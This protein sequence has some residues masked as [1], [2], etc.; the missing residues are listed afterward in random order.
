M[1]KAGG[2]AAVYVA[3]SRVGF[4]VALTGGGTPP[5]WHPAGFAVAA[6][7]LCGVTLWPGVLVGAVIASLITGAPPLA[8]AFAGAGATLEALVAT[9]LLRRMGFRPQLERL[10]DV[11]L[12]V[13]ATAIAAV[14]AASLGVAGLALGGDVGTRG[15]LFAWATWAAGDAVSILLVGGLLLTWS[16]NPAI[17]WLARRPRE[18]LVALGCVAVASVVLFFDIFGLRAQGES[19]AFPIIPLVV[20]V[21]FRVGPRGTTLAS[22]LFSVIALVATNRGLGPFVGTTREDSLL[23]LVIFIALTAVS[24][25]AV[26][27]VVAE[28]E[29]SASALGSAVDALAQ[30]REALA[31]RAATYGRLLDYSERI[32]GLLAE[33]ELYRVCVEALDAVVPADL[34]GLTVLE[35]SSGEYVVR[36]EQGSSG[37]VGGVIGPGEGPAGCA[38]RDRHVVRMAPYPRESFPVALRERNAADE[39]AVA[40]GIPLLRDDVAIGSLT[41]A[42]VDP[43]APFTDLEMEALTLLSHEV[44]LAVANAL[45]HT[46]VADRAI[47]D[48]LT[49]LHNRRYFDAAMLHLMAM[50]ARVPAEQRGPLSVILFDLD[51]FGDLNLHHGHQ[52]GDEVL[53]AFGSILHGRLR[54]ADLV[55]RYGG[56]EFI[57]VLSGAD[58]EDALRIA[59]EIRQA[60]A[61]A[62]IQGIDGNPLS[63]TVSAG[64]TAVSHDG[65]GTGESLIR[66]ADVGLIMAKRSGR[67]RVVAA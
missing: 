66:A 21:A 61:A 64:C 7:F 60:L 46:E 45:L 31:T 34:V 18:T 11:P 26:A 63:V 16:A 53:R 52:V 30:E 59:D 39:Y 33:G 56:E 43:S 55:A 12:L 23:Y 8:A 22:V 20:W 14:V 17:D 44:S 13:L 35:R 57:V 5:L 32:A 6:L 1:L 4:A 24:G 29:A 49:G 15:A 38:I 48:G 27:A 2:L 25:E 58:R 10:L 67:N 9:G 3:A 51:Q 50:R 47:H 19:V 62:L 40:I 36:A 54:E 65:D 37:S 41:V 28:R 42:R